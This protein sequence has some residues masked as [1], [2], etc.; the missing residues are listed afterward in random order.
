M[1][2]Y[3]AKGIVGEAGANRRYIRKIRQIWRY[4]HAASQRSRFRRLGLEILDDRGLATDPRNRFSASRSPPL[5]L[6]FIGLAGKTISLVG[7]SIPH[8]RIRPGNEIQWICAINRGATGAVFL[9]AGIRREEQAER[10]CF[11]R[12]RRNRP[13]G[14]GSARFPYSVL[15][16]GRG[17]N[18]LA[19]IPMLAGINGR[20]VP[21]GADLHGRRHRTCRAGVDNRPGCSAARVPRATAQAGPRCSE[22]RRSAICASRRI[23]GVGVTAAVLEGSAM[24]S[25]TEPLYRQNCQ[26]PN[27]L[28]HRRNVG[29]APNSPLV[30][31]SLQ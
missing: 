2:A 25:G 18:F 5:F 13:A 23:R 30:P 28:W 24:D 10:P 26:F 8:E 11:P 22:P 15:R 1:L 7:L 12:T 16:L 29:S 17:A 20:E 3:G 31:G 21:A 27:N 6:L 9:L 19:I 14:K 4:P